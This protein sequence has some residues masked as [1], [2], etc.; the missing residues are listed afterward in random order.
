MQN[1]HPRSL[2]FFQAGRYSL[3]YDSLDLLVIPWTI[4]KTLSDKAFGKAGLFL[5]N[6]LFV[7]IRTAASVEA[8]E[9]FPFRE[10]IWQLT[11]LAQICDC[12]HFHFGSFNHRIDTITNKA[13]EYL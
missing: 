10:S 2:A 13:F 6:E 3:C 11:F 4:L 9:D 7:D 12:T 8:A 5:W 1:H